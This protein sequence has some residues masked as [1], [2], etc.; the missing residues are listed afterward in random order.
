MAE[1][2]SSLLRKQTADLKTHLFPALMHM[3]AQPLYQ[4]SIE[5][6]AENIEEELQARNDPASVAADNVNRL[7][8]HLG[9]KTIIACTTQIIK[10]A[11]EQ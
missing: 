8:S 11:I 7:A 9:E 4:D 2:V 10:E 5:E 6:W 3:L 1:S